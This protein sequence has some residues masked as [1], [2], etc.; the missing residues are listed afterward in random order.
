MPSLPE[1]HKEQPQHKLPKEVLITL[2]YFQK[3]LVFMCKQ[4]ESIVSLFS[5]DYPL[6]YSI[7][8][9]HRNIFWQFFFRG[10][11]HLLKCLRFFE[12][13]LLS[14][15]PLRVCCL[16]LSVTIISLISFKGNKVTISCFDCNARQSRL[17][18]LTTF[19]TNNKTS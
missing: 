10:F 4:F 14:Q 18:Y 16:V 3:C 13:V 1:D 15:G 9:V 5:H 7:K 17:F 8:T 19:N 2:G 6:A 12:V 11:A